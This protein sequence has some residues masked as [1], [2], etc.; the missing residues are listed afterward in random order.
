MSHHDR[1]YCTVPY[2]LT[3]PTV[4]SVVMES[5]DTCRRSLDGSL[6]VLKWEGIQPSEL[7]G[8]T[9]LSHAEALALMATEAWSPPSP[10]DEE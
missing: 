10:E 1:T 6:V 2:P 9:P 8:A 5:E 3:D 7:A 4:W